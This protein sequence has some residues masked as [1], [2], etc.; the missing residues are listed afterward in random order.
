MYKRQPIREEPPKEE[1]P[2]KEKPLAKEEPQI[3][4]EE[5]KPLL[6]RPPE[7]A[8]KA[9]EVRKESA[10]DLR[11]LLQNVS[12]PARSKLDDRDPFNY[13]LNPNTAGALLFGIL[14]FLMLSSLI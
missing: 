7:P 2:V 3:L 13:L 8:K 1:P 11:G 14:A 6:E 12:L 10:N 9:T 5:D 4:L